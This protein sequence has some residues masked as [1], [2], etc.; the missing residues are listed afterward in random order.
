MIRFDQLNGKE[1]QKAIS[2]ASNTSSIIFRFRYSKKNN[3]IILVDAKSKRPEKDTF[4]KYIVVCQLPRANFL[5]YCMSFNG[6]INSMSNVISFDDFIDYNTLTSE[7]KK[8]IFWVFYLP[9]DLL[10][11]HNILSSPKHDTEL[12]IRLFEYL[13]KFYEKKAMI[14]KYN[15]STPNEQIILCLKK[16]YRVTGIKSYLITI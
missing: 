15:Y 3:E 16:I 5:Q 6:S 2:R 10:L 4:E 14:R 8:K 12:I 7:G 9:E 13:Y 11:Y 1:I